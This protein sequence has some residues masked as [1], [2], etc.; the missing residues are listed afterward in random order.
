MQVGTNCSH[1]SLIQYNQ[2]Q[3]YCKAASSGL[4][5]RGTRD[6]RKCRATRER[7]RFKARCRQVLAG[8]SPGKQTPALNLE[9]G[10]PDPALSLTYL[11]DIY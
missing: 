4:G 9:P 3:S 10:I 1:Y 7:G 11:G 8:G 2:V 6:S 5:L